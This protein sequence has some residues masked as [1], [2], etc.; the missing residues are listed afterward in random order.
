MAARKHLLLLLLAACALA[1]LPLALGARGALC[2]GRDRARVMDCLC[3]KR[4]P[5]IARRS[6]VR[7]QKLTLDPTARTHF[8]PPQK[9][10][11][12]QQLTATLTCRTAKDFSHR[13]T[14]A[15]ADALAPSHHKRR[16]HQRHLSQTTADGHDPKRANKCVATYLRVGADALRAQVPTCV[17]GGELQ[18][19]CVEARAL[20]NTGGALGECEFF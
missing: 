20:L 7:T 13:L 16:H 2:W 1:A 3:D 17:A 10:L 6:T 11:P 5:L 4:V 12:S 8:R 9:T 18:A 14:E 15:A 19:C